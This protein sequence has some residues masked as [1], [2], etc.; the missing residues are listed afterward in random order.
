M[1]NAANRVVTNC[2]VSESMIM[3]LLLLFAHSLFFL[4]FS[5]TF[6][7]QLMFVFWYNERG[8]LALALEIHKSCLLTVTLVSRIKLTSVGVHSP[9]TLCSLIR[10]FLLYQNPAVGSCGRRN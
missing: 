1:T 8:T 10:L 9:L 3:L 7:V 6:C 2:S 5:E 4:F